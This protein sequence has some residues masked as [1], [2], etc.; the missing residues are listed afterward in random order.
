ME[1]VASRDGDR[2]VLG[3]N[4]RGPGFAEEL[5]PQIGKP[6]NSSKGRPGGGLGLFLVVNVVRK[7]GGEVRVRNRRGGGASVTVILP[8][9]SLE[10]GGDGGA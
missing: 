9:K 6:Y 8:L 2:L 10:I 3:V 7:L 5:L 4:D 1:L